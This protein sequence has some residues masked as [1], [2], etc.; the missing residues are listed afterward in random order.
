MPRF[1]YE[2]INSQGRRQIDSREAGSRDDVIL[3]LQ[4]KGLTLV[5]WMDEKPSLQLLFKKSTRT[6]NSKDLLTITREMAHLM[7][8]G[9]PMDR[10]LTIIVQTSESK[11]LCGMATYL[12]ESLQSGKSLSDAMGD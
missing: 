12:K 4:S 10:A 6:L 9:L 7:K 2:V 3:F 11:T 1:S 8:S 5:R